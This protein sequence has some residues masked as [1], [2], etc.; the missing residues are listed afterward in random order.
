MVGVEAMRGLCKIHGCYV[1]HDD[2][3]VRN[4]LVVSENRVVWVDFDESRTL[5]IPRKSEA[6]PPLLTRLDFWKEASEVWT[7]LYHAM[8]SLASRF[9]CK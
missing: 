7:K 8:V 9:T 6:D 2:H 5:G 4:C 3:L 1:L